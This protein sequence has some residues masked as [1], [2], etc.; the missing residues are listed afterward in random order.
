MKNKFLNLL[1]LFCCLGLF[2]GSVN[3]EGD[4]DDASR[5]DFSMFEPKGTTTEETKKD[6]TSLCSKYKDVTER[7]NCCNQDDTSNGRYECKKSLYDV[8]MNKQS[9]ISR[10]SCC[11]STFTGDELT[12]CKNTAI[13]YCDV[14]D[15]VKLSKTAAAIKIEYEPNVLKA[16]GFDDPNSPYYSVFIYALDIKIY[17]L[18]DDVYV[19]VETDKDVS[20]SVDSSNI[21]PE[22]YVTLR[23]DSVSEIRNYTFKVYSNTGNCESEPLRTIKLSTPKFN[24]LSSREACKEVPH[25][26]KCQEFVSYDFEV[27]NYIKDIE[28]YKEKLAKQGVKDADKD[29]VANKGVVSKAVKKVSDNKWIVLAIIIV[30]GLAITFVLAKKRKDD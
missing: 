25:F 19:A 28:D 20:Y 22:G 17:N 4:Y 3:A 18:T 6:Y 29:S 24:H 26:Y 30:I 21:G 11:E 1:F 13:S 27:G 7:V 23:D 9:P 2:I 10:M 15:K 14:T 5:Y 8:C 12:D 16:E